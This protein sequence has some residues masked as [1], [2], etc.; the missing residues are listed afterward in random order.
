M[1]AV[2]KRLGVFQSKQLF[3]IKKKNIVYF[4]RAKRFLVVKIHYI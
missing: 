4:Y 2:R 1:T 3:Y